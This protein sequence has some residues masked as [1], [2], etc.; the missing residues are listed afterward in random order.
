MRKEPSTGMR[1]VRAV[2]I[3]LE[4]ALIGFLVW[5]VRGVRLG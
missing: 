5:W 4:A 2:I 3:V 1:I